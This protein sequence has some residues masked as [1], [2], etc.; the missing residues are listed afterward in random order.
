M[1]KYENVPKSNSIKNYPVQ[2]DSFII[3]KILNEEDPLKPFIE[4]EIIPNKIK[5]EE[6]EEDEDEKKEDDKNIIFVECILVG[7]LFYVFTHQGI[8]C[9]MGKIIQDLS[10]SNWILNNLWIVFI[11]MWYI[12]RTHIINLIL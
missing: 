11:I 2:L 3:D 1:D 7:C 6:K 8:Q 10:Q 12:I 5:K 4:P 9:F